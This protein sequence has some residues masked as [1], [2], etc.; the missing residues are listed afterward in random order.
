MTLSTETKPIKW[1]GRR[2][3]AGRFV[4]GNKDVLP[5]RINTGA[6][7]D[8]IPARDLWVSPEHALYLDEAL[9]PARHLV[10]GVS[11]IQVEDVASVEY[12]HIELEAHDVIVAEGAFVE[13]FV[14]DDSRMM[15]HNAMEYFRLYPNEGRVPAL[16]CAPRIEDGFGL[17]AIRRRLQG[18]ARR[19]A[20]DG[21]APA[22]RI[23]GHLDLVRHDLIEGWAFDRT[24]PAAAATVVILANGAEIA[25]L[26]ADRYRDDLAA[27]GIGD[28]C[29]AFSLAVPGGLSSDTR[30]AIEVYGWPDWAPLTGSPYTLEPARTLSAA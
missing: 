7:A 13:S 17:E 10:N 16:F 2:S 14:D 3:Y 6:L 28:G 30:L 20:A 5:I 1:I 23:E 27:A 26:V 8:R 19:L 25:R 22:A 21:T 29:H 4:A 12:F 15:F 18:R 24:T 9:V 11:I